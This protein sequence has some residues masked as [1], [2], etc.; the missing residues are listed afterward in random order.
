MLLK[1]RWDFRLSGSNRSKWKIVELLKKSTISVLCKVWISSR[2]CAKLSCIVV[3]IRVK[4]VE[5]ILSIKARPSCSRIHLYQHDCMGIGRE[6]K[7]MIQLHNF[8]RRN[9]I[10]PPKKKRIKNC[11][12]TSCLPF[13]LISKRFAVSSGNSW[14]CLHCFPNK[15]FSRDYSL[16]TQTL[17]KRM[18]QLPRQDSEEEK[19]KWFKLNCL[20]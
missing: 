4:W 8:H 9:D 2:H 17:L 20:V 7:N 16:A 15:T 14:Q 5:L 1:Q 19:K 12:K 13:R 18:E 10:W 6:M 3:G 11:H